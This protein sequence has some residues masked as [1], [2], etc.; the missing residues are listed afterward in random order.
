[1]PVKRLWTA[2][3]EATLRGL[4][5]AGETTTAIAP[6]FNCSRQTILTKAKEIGA[7]Q[8]RPV[9]RQKPRASG[10]AKSQHTTAYHDDRSWE[11]LP[12]G[13]PETW[14]AIAH[15]PWPGPYQEDR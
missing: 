3:E 12:P 2:D 11:P 1:M 9:G 5:V 6:R 13:H 4:I 14:G 10:R 7:M 15:A 8:P